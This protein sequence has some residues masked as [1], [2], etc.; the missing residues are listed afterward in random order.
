M[1]KATLFNALT[2]KSVPAENYP[3]CTIDPS[4][5]I[6]AVPDRRLETLAA[7]SRS[8][9]TIPAV[10]E[11]VDIAGLVRGAAEGEGLGNQFLAHIRE[12]DMIAE[13]VRIFDDENVAH[14]SGA[15]DPLAD[16]GAVNL[17]LVLKDLE[18]LSNRLA[19]T[20]REVKRGEKKAAEEAALLARVREHLEKGQMART[21]VLNKKA[22]GHNLDEHND[23]RWDALMNFLAESGSE[24][25]LV[26]AGVENELK[27]LS[28][29][30]KQEFRREYGTQDSGIADLIRA[31][32]RLLGLISFFT[33][34]ED[35]TRGWTVPRGA[36][37]PEAGG[38]IHSDF[39]DK[40]IRASV[41]G[42]EDLARSGSRAAA[43]EQGLLRTEGREY[44]VQNG[45]VIE[46]LI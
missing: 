10:V 22:G 17:E 34:G 25:A 41:V 14:V 40:F 38:A 1:W 36:S 26:D 8:A 24:Y 43:R 7:L 29:D 12:T 32:Y 4:V 31:C 39:R 2:Q 35:E 19:S 16:I 23:E 3:F 45:D 11:F 27:D 37:A 5:G 15:V 46:F 44:I 30:E 28:E 9:K 6:V 42:Y 33:T 13:V 20:E 18:T 21:L